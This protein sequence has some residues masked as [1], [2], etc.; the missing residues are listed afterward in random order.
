MNCKE[1]ISIVFSV[2]NSGKEIGKS[3]KSIKEQNPDQIIVVDG[4]SSDNT[5]NEAKRYTNDVFVA[6]QGKWNQL[7]VALSKIEYSTVIFAEVDHFYPKDFL[8]NF[9]KEYKDSDYF[10]MSGTLECYFTNTFFEKGINQFYKIHQYEKGKKDIIGGPAIFKTLPYKEIINDLDGWNGYSIDTRRA[11][12]FE[13]NNLSL[14]LGHTVA[15][16]YQKLDLKGF[17]KKYFN[18][19]KG[20]HTFYNFNKKNW[21]LKRKLRSI[22]HVFNRY[23]IDYPLKSFTVGKPYIA[24][25]F[26]WLSAI[27]RYSGWIYSIITKGNR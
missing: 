22:F 14:G 18:Y 4:G 1:G 26:L 10:G 17:L 7:K 12:L 20:D 16:Q 25:P 9:I 6:K 13:Q 5:V 3:L 8:K 23:I 27:V 24:V 21:T 15:Y 2:L 19:G 11:Q